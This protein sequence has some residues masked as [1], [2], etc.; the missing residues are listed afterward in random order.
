[1][2]FSSQIQVL[3]SPLHGFNIY[4]IAQYETRQLDAE[5][6]CTADV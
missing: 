5:Y 3:F 2:C 6:Q 4:F 1:M